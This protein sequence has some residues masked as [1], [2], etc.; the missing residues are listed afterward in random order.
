MNLSAMLWRVLTYVH[1]RLE[2]SLSLVPD[3]NRSAVEATPLRREVGDEVVIV[4]HHAGRSEDGGVRKRL[5][6]AVLAL[7]L[8]AN[9][10]VSSN[11]D[12]TH[13]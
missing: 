8:Q 11:A 3:R 9:T 10:T 1:W 5:H 6:N 12:P 7:L 4:A 13:T 2:R